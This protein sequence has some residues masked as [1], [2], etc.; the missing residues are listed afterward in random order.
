MNCVMICLYNFLTEKSILKKLLPFKNSV[1]LFYALANSTF[2][3][4]TISTVMLTFRQFLRDMLCLFDQWLPV[5]TVLL[6]STVHRDLRQRRTALMASGRPLNRLHVPSAP[7]ENTAP[8]LLRLIAL[9]VPTPWEWPPPAPTAQLVCQYHFISYTLCF[10]WWRLIQ[11]ML[12]W[13]E[14]CFMLF[15]IW[16]IWLKHKH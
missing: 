10:C 14:Y 6:G 3:R 7:L 2:R 12:V 9:V 11:L 16:F 15:L 8:R 1:N 13:K 5:L 4:V